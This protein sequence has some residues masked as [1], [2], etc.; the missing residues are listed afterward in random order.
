MLVCV[1]MRKTDKSLGLYGG[2]C[3]LGRVVAE[4][5]HAA[6]AA[7][8]VC[9]GWE[10]QCAGIAACCCGVHQP[11][12][13]PFRCSTLV[14]LA[15][16]PPHTSL[17]CARVSSVCSRV[18]VSICARGIRV[19]IATCIAGQTW[20]MSCAC[21]NTHCMHVYACACVDVGMAGAEAADSVSTRWRGERHRGGGR[22]ARDRRF[23]RAPRRPGGR[24]VRP[25]RQCERPE[26][27]RR[28]AE[29]RGDH[30]GP[31]GGRRAHHRPVCAGDLGLP[32]GADEEAAGAA[33]APP[34]PR[35]G[36][37]YAMS[38]HAWR[39]ATCSRGIG[40]K[41]RPPE[42]LLSTKHIRGRGMRRHIHVHTTA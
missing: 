37:V 14:R 36:N 33:V 2:A 4:T 23:Q 1:R 39:V 32:Q 29:L 41:P 24:G 27:Q 5:V 13:A 18:A 28:H 8:A 42:Q 21:M 17:T 34:P 38:L 40:R 35:L 30:G 6:V 11:S 7:A 26:R 22:P 16:Y 25:V 3:V 31:G 15:W 9:A 20:R 12:A 19:A 10:R